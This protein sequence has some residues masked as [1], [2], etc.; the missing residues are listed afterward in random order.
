MKG[1][2]FQEFISM[3]ETKFSLEIADKMMTSS[4]L[5]TG[6]A[7]ASVGTYHHGEIVEMVGHLSV[8]TGVKVPDLL[9]TFGQYLFKSLTMRYPNHI[10]NVPTT[11]ALL[12]VLDS[13]IHVDVKKLYP[14]A[15]L[16]KFQVSN[17]DPEIMILLYRSTRP[18]S[19][20]AEGMINAAIQH[21]NESISVTREDIPCQEGAHTQFTLTKTNHA[22]AR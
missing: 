9:R 6:G 7:Y 5:L 14:D 4:S 13:K 10:K 8:A 19:D 3:V 20:L 18:F 11:Y 12:S 17:L 2:I 1:V 22:D 21:F 16:P 15:E